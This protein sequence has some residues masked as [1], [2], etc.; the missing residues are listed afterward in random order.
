M[1]DSMYIKF[2]NTSNSSMVMEVR[3][4]V[5]YRGGMLIVVGL[6]KYVGVVKVF[7]ILKYNVYKILSSC[8]LKVFYSTCKLYFNGVLSA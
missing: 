1:Y 8:T 5:T 4:V 7:S 2:T 3:I 6:K